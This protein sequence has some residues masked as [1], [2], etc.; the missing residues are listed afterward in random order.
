[1][2]DLASAAGMNVASLYH[3]FPSK[4]ALLA[5]VIEQSGHADILSGQPPPIP[6]GMSEQDAI[7][8]LLTESWKAML[9]VEDSVRVMLGEALRH[10]ATATAV[11]TDLRVHTRA[12]LEEWIT[13]ATP[14]LAGTVG[15]APLARL[16]YTVLVG[17]F[18]DHLTAPTAETRPTLQQYAADVARLLC[19]GRSPGE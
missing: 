8:L 4:S 1:M 14:G 10:E 15:A 17:V 19:G 5:T 18:V 3:Y 16:L 13:E 12:W 9:E 7:E 11:G 6:V 2:R